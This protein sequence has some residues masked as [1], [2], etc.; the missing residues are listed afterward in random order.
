MKGKSL[1]IYVVLATFFPIVGGVEKQA[2]AQCQRLQQKDHHV[3]VITFRHDSLWQKY[4]EIGGLQI[5]RV[6]GLLLGS[7]KRL[8]VVLQKVLYLLSI[9]VIGWLLWQRRKQYDV[10]HV[11]QLNLLALPASLICRFAGKPLIVAMHSAGPGKTGSSFS[12]PSL[13]GG[14]LDSGMPYLQINE[15][16]KGGGDLERLR[17]QG[18]LTFGLIRALLHHPNIVMVVLSS[19]MKKYVLAQGFPF[20]DGQIIPNGVDINHFRPLSPV[21]TIDVTNTVVCVSRLSYEKGIDVLLQAWHIVHQELPQAKLIIVGSGTLRVQ[22]E[23]MAE[24]LNIMGSVEFVGLQQDVIAQLQRGCIA[25]LPSRWEGMPVA[26]LEA[27][28]CG[29]PCVAARVSGSE[30]IIQHGKNGLLFDPED[31]A[32]MAAELVSLLRNTSLRVEYGASA[33]AT[34]ESHYSLESVTD[35][36]VTLYQRSIHNHMRVK[37]PEELQE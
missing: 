22:L 19:R 21:S 3:T 9:V 15:T 33:R 24:A 27:M 7:R 14:P 29:L 28:A 2:L 8:P 23:Q 37:V 25:T 36:Y 12:Q 30:D 6:A 16:V 34:I 32:T 17:N 18:K 1:H 35:A 31:Y 20:S 5:I 26:I 10:L 11:Y 13:L 4:E